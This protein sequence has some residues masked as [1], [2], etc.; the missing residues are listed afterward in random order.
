MHNVWTML[1]HVLLVAI[2]MASLAFCFP[3]KMMKESEDRRKYQVHGIRLDLN[4]MQL[5][6]RVPVTHLL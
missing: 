1:T 6:D 4:P 5:C 3:D 2:T